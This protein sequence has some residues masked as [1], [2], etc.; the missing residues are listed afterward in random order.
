MTK[1]PAQLDREIEDND[2]AAFVRGAKKY[3]P[4]ERARL[5]YMVDGILRD[6]GISTAG[7]RDDEALVALARAE[8]A[9]G[10]SEVVR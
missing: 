8:L 2:L 9:R 7:A 3:S 1:T 5:A 4:L 6:R 10:S